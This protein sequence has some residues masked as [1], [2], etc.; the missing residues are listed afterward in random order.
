MTVDKIARVQIS[1]ANLPLANSSRVVF[2]GGRITC[3]DLMLLNVFII[4]PT[5]N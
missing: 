3:D 5:R 2:T 4:G 1:L